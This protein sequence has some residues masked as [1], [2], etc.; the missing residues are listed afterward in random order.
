MLQFLI[1]VWPSFLTS[2]FLGFVIN[3][4]LYIINLKLSSANALSEK[5]VTLEHN[6]LYL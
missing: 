2:Q 4:F 5:E 1:F 3:L 6:I